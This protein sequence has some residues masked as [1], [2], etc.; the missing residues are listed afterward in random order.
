MT[1]VEK[2]GNMNKKE[3][4]Y[5]I[6]QMLKLEI[7]NNTHLCEEALIIE[8]AGGKELKLKVI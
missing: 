6:S 3:F 2:G 5:L 8:L 7:T 1:V 4:L